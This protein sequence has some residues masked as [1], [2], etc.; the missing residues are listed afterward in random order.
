[1]TGE[2]ECGDATTANIMLCLHTHILKDGNIFSSLYHEIFNI[3]YSEKDY[4]FINH[5]PRVALMC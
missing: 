5:S 1:M 4:L 2:G 3:M